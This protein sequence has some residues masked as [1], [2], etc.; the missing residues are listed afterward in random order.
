MRL[1][2]CCRALAVFGFI[3][4]SISQGL[5]QRVVYFVAEACLNAQTY[6]GGHQDIARAGVF[7]R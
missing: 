3:L 7:I 1:F 5:A 6:A 4:L 2:A